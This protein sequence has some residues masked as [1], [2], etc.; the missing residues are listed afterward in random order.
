MSLLLPLC[1]ALSVRA[2]DGVW[3][4][5]AG[6]W[7]DS[8]N[9]QDGIVPQTAGDTASFIGTGGNIRI[10]DDQPFSLSAIYA[11]TN[12]ANAYVTLQGGGGNTLIAPA[13]IRVEPV[14]LTLAIPLA[15]TDGLAKTGLGALNLDCETNR[16]SGPVSVT[17]G[18]VLR[19]RTD[20]ALGAVPSGLDADAVILDNG[21]LGTWGA[22]LTLAPTRGITAGSGGAWFLARSTFNLT[23]G[24]PVT[25]PGSVSVAKQSA[26]VIFSN[27]GND[28]AGDTILGT[29]NRDWLNNETARGRLVLGADE[30]IPHGAGRGVLRFAGDKKG[31]LDLNGHS[32]TVGSVVATQGLSLVNGAVA[33]GVLTAGGDNA[34]M[35][36]AGEIGGGATLKKIGS[37][38]LNFF[39]SANST[40]TLH[41]VQGPFVF[42]AGES[43][44]GLTLRMDG[45]S[46]QVADSLPGLTERRINAASW[47]VDQALAFNNVLPG[48]EKGFRENT[49]FGYNTHIGYFGRW[50][51]P[52]AGV[53]SFAKSFDDAAGLKLDGIQLL[54][55]GAASGL[56]VTQHVA[57][58]A[59]WHDVE[60]RFFNGT[61]VAGPYSSHSFSAGIV[62]DPTDS[63]LDTPAL[64][65]AAFRF[66]DGAAGTSLRTTPLGTSEN[67]A[68]ARLELAQD[69]TLDRSGA[70]SSPLRWAGDLVPAVGTQ[71][72]PK[73]TVAGGSGPLRFGGTSRPAVFDVDVACAD[74]V[75]F[76]NIAWIKSWPVS[77]AYTIGAGTELAAG[78]PGILG[79]S[80][81]DL[82]AV[83]Y[84]KLRIP[85]ADTGIGAVAVPAN[86][87][88]RFDATREAGGR[89]YGDSGY[90]FTADNDV[91]LG[92]GSA[93]IAFDGAGT[94]V[95][96]GTLTGSGRIVKNGAAGTAVL[97]QPSTFE[98]LIQI[99]QGAVLLGDAAAL[100]VATNAI[101]FDG[102]TLGSADGAA[103]TLPYPM[104]ISASGGAFD[105]PAAGWTLT[106]TL[107]GTL[108]KRGPGALTLGGADTNAA[109]DLAVE[110]GTVLL[111]KN[112]AVRDI[113]RIAPNAAARLAA[114]GG[115]LVTRSLTLHG[116]TFDLNG[117]SEAVSG[118]NSDVWGCTLI[119][120]GAAPAALS[121][122]SGAF[123]GSLRD[124]AAALGL[125][126]TGTGELWLY[127]DPAGM[128]Y[129]G[130]T[131]VE[132]G[133]LN[134]SIPVTFIRM[135]VTKTRGGGVAGISEFRVLRGGEWLP[136]PAGTVASASSQN[137]STGG[138]ERLID[139]DTATKWQALSSATGNPW[140]RLEFPSAVAIDGYAWYTRDDHS[141]N[142]P[143]SWKIEISRNG[144]S[145]HLADEQTDAAVTVTR[146]MQAGAWTL[147]DPYA[148]NRS[149]PAGS[150]VTVAAGATA[151]VNAPYAAVAALAGAGTVSLVDGATLA[152]GDIS[153]F[154]GKIAG[155]G[156]V[157]SA[158]E[159][160]VGAAASDVTFAGA[161]VLSNGAFR[162]SVRDGAV[163]G[164]LVKRGPDTAVLYG[165]ASAYSGGTSVEGG[166]LA[167]PPPIAAYRYVRFR[168]TEV[169]DPLNASGGNRVSLGEFQLTL[170]GAPVALPP[171]TVASASSEHSAPYGASRA[172]DGDWTNSTGRFISGSGMPVWLKLDMPQPV[173]FDGYQWYT[174]SDGNYDRYRDPVSWTFEGSHDGTN[175]TL[176]DSHA[177]ESYPE[178]RTA[179]VGP[180]VVSAAP[181]RLPPALWAAVEGDRVAAVAARYLRFT[182]TRTRPTGDYAGSG[183]QF[184][185]LELR[186]DGATVPWPG[187]SVATAPG[188][189]F[190]DAS[191]FLTPDKVVDNILPV[192]GNNNRWY[193]TSVVNP[194]TVDMGAPVAFNG[195][196]LWT[197]YL[198]AGRDP[199]SWTLEISGDGV[200]W[201]LA[202]TQTDQLYS[203]ARNVCAG[204]WT[205]GFDARSEA[206]AAALP[207]A[208][209]VFVAFG[210]TLLLDGAAERVGPLSGAGAVALRN[211][212]ALDINVS[213]DAAFDG[214]FT[215]QGTLAVGGAA[216][217]SF[218]DADIS[219]VTNLVLRGGAGVSAH[220]ALAGTASTSGDLSVTFAGGA[221][222]AATIAVSGALSVSGAARYA[223]PEGAAFP[224][225]R[226]LFTF[227]TLDAAS[228][229]ALR[230]G[231]A[232]LDVPRGYAA[233]VRITD[234]AA[235]LT[236]SAPGLILT[237]K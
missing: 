42:S 5:G 129:T 24:A 166:T 229:A 169:R 162:A 89:L 231:A 98:G 27:P 88:V 106:G 99:S 181:A 63:A 103:I 72:V 81:I 86:K 16:F 183:V 133:T 38:A 207:D 14:E 90:A 178:T 3:T 32:E 51:V 62:F 122:G 144:S 29:E 124:G 213:E 138:P 179:K 84:A 219:G 68:A 58:A 203:T 202:D 82:A 4:G 199:V 210:A 78:S 115:N 107:S 137:G 52:E 30:V 75:T 136:L 170:G 205:F 186:R 148:G 134:W 177:K 237:V 194:L 182:P 224:Y 105:I 9:W 1:L 167:L 153:A 64:Q 235:V 33:P 49:D 8:A 116:G 53:Y 54:N 25:G 217:Q 37:G 142:D 180:F 113:T 175:W 18:G 56:A 36:L 121:V 225:S 59:G 50:H 139:T 236:V 69:V 174:A 128:T 147:L 150:A 140:I 212:A 109:L 118:L 112:G 43:L 60:I 204:E 34:D 131:L 143:V 196:R 97:T 61:G 191:Q 55:N 77:S 158:G 94:V 79:S 233:T 201:Y 157:S 117:H 160:T 218:A 171:G 102:G 15:G 226:T 66:E 185:E 22:A 70:A 125:T 165:S 154:A 149:V 28:Y 146:R 172:I 108:T 214:A 74:G 85:S 206:C 92:G 44:G 200:T 161:V 6:S 187:G 234:S 57:V 80:D 87:V 220:A 155:G 141:E 26:A 110:E 132:A 17:E 83:P 11:N 10:P 173:T 35:R 209:P 104:A 126:K 159:I 230:A 163:L 41:L 221:Y 193:S 216:T 222:G 127:G 21:G 135:T 120:N 232:A 67:A 45:G 73:L 2:A 164:R 211:G 130:P 227:G 223:L 198:G 156:T 47:N 71:G 215:G 91:S 119:N 19:V 96:T 20:G 123:R 100:G 7:T 65:T 23:V 176:L 48:T 151:A 208:A 111:A 114:A 145:W 188:G 101:T 39:A 76:Q 46:L 228:R 95:Y 190:T 40:G 195:Y 31:V 184:A 152:V 12:G 197:A 13:T 93:A 168:V 189:G 192:A